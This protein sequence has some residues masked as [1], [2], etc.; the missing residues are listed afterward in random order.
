MAIFVRI[1]IE[2]ISKVDNQFLHHVELY[3]LHLHHP[4]QHLSTL[5]FL[6]KI[7]Q[8]ICLYH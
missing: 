2:L 5:I 7:K 8:S 1:Q 6:T 3:L 4:Y